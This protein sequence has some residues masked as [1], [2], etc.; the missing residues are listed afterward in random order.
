MYS[1]GRDGDLRDVW[2]RVT[3]EIPIE[4]SSDTS[5]KGKIMTVLGKEQLIEHS[6]DDITAEIS[7]IGK[8]LRDHGAKKVALYLPNSIELLAAL[9]AGAFYGFSPVLIPYNQPHPT[10]VELLSRTGADT[11]IAQAGS[12]PLDVVS[13]GVSGLREVIWT[14]EKTSRHMDWNEV[15]EGIGGKIDVSVWHQLIQDQKNG[16]PQLPTTTEKAPNLVF[17]WQGGL[18]DSFEV[19]EFTQQVRSPLSTHFITANQY[20]TFLLPL[21]H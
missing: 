18:S 3:G 4:K 9:F 6:I 7:I 2:R 13:Q 5:A 8:Y 10:L 11:L 16:P 20:R 1:A 21:V 14:V 17:L 19:V 15:P 12:V